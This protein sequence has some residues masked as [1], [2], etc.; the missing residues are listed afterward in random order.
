VPTKVFAGFALQDDPKI[1]VTKIPGHWLLSKTTPSWRIKD[2]ELGFQRMVREVRARE[3]ALA[4]LDQK[5]AFPNAIVL[6]TDAPEFSSKNGKLRIPEDI[7]FLVVDGQH[8]LWA[9]KFSTF[10]ADY[11]CVIHTGLTEEDMAHL[12]LE[13]NDNQRRVP[14]SLRWDLYRL[15]QKDVDPWNL[16]AAEL[17]Y[18]LSTDDTS[19]L[20]QRIDRTGEQSEIALKQ[21]SLAPGLRQAFKKIGNRYALSF[22]DQYQLIVQYLIAIRDLDPDTWGNPKKSPFYMA[23]VLRALLRLLPDIVTEEESWELDSNRFR[24]YLKR[25]DQKSL[26]LKKI[27]QVQGSAGMKAIYDQ[28]HSQVFPGSQE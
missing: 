16:A 19:P 9:Q 24:T 18:A 4:V 6:A 15:V 3:I 14:S 11:A 1:Y 7:K 10:E 20:F 25:I 28:I 5:R 22:N 23:R 13:I 21:G 8:R 26:D 12:F 17:V 27:R 2:P